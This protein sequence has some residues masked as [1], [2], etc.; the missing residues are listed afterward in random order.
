MLELNGYEQRPRTTFIISC[1]EILINVQGTKLN[2]FFSVP[3]KVKALKNE[4]QNDN[5]DREGLEG[6]KTPS[7]ARERI[8]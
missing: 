2:Y 7:P 3:V 1:F 4:L 5:P 8:E 6:E